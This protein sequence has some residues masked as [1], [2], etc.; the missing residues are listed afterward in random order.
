MHHFDSIY[1]FYRILSD[2]HVMLGTQESSTKTVCEKCVANNIC[3]SVITFFK[4]Q[5]S[6]DR[7]KV[8][9][10]LNNKKYDKSYSRKR[11]RKKIARVR[12]LDRWYLV[13]IT[14]FAKNT[15]SNNPLETKQ[16]DFVFVLHEC[17]RKCLLDELYVSSNNK[18]VAN[19]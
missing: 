19:Y 18:C 9:Q 13:T 4:N 14:A 8:T 5:L 17:L 12:M 1:L 2:N 3:T 11:Q 16:I 7:K 15:N 10:F 6:Y